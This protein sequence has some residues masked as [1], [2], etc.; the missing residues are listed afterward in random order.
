MIAEH[1]IRVPPGSFC[2]IKRDIGLPRQLNR[3][4]FTLCGRCAHASTDRNVNPINLE[5]FSEVLHNLIGDDTSVLGICI[6]EQDNKFIA[7][8]PAD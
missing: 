1:R 4:G 2:V 6:L 8:D 3:V 5:G 7:P